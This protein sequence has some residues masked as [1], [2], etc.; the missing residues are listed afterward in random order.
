LRR[1]REAQNGTASATAAAIGKAASTIAAAQPNGV[2]TSTRPATH[3]SASAASG[4]PVGVGRFDQ[5][6]PAVS[7]KPTTTASVKPNSI[8]CACH[9]GPDR[10]GWPSQPAT[11]AAHRPIDSAAKLLASR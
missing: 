4:R 5:L 9:S 7:K 11:C 8:S 6:R 3:S 2:S 10:Y 1:L